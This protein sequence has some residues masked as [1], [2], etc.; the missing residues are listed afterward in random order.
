MV[1]NIGKMR[2][3]ETKY[4]LEEIKQVVAAGKGALIKVI[5]ENAYLD[6]DQKVSAY[7]AVEAAGANPVKTSTGFAPT[8]ATVED[9]LTDA[10]DGWTERPSESR[11]WCPDP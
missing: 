4:V 10:S 11:P 8:G 5:L 2:S 9:L 6:H 1:I 3:G 7:L